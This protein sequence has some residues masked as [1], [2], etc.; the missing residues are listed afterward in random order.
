MMNPEED[1][2][3]NDADTDDS[4]I[5]KNINDLLDSGKSLTISTSIQ[6]KFLNQLSK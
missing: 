1:D 5:M 3:L 2:Y 4:E 6:S